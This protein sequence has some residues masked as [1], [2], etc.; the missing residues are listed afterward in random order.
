MYESKSALQHQT[1][2]QSDDVGFSSRRQ[3]ICA[4]RAGL[5]PLDGEEIKGD[6]PGSMDN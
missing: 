3:K 6:I 4:Q 5:I 1:G 2:P